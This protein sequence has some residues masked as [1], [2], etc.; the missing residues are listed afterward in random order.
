M[1]LIR[2][3]EFI[4]FDWEAVVPGYTRNLPHITQPGVMY[5]ITFRLADAVPTEIAERWKRERD[6]WLTRHPKPWD[7]VVEAEFRRRFTARMERWMDAGH[8][9][10]LLRQPEHREEVRRCLVHDDQAQHDLGDFVI[11]PNHVHLLLRPKKAVQL[12]TLLR[13]IKGVSARNINGATGN[14]G[15]LWQ[16]ES[17]DHIVRSVDQ[18]RRMQEYIRD[19]PIKAG[20]KSDEFT[21]EERWQ[22][23]E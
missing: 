18:L 22:I 7:A 11:M 4:P 20:L 3:K 8:G 10:C 13:P 17:F 5:F 15:A 9:S 1:L 14:S 19:N 21:H 2:R 16:G 12:K 23:E 6:E